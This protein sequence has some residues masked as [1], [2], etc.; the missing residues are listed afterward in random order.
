MLDGNDGA[1]VGSTVMGIEF[2]VSLG[3]KKL[4]SGVQEGVQDSLIVGVV[5]S[6]SRGLL[7]CYYVVCS[8]CYQYSSSHL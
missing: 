7:L 4:G 2:M 3:V 6:L 5:H 1:G 8:S